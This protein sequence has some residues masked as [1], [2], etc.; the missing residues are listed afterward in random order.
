MELNRQ[1]YRRLTTDQVATA[2]CTDPVQ[3]RFLTSERIVIHVDNK[4]PISYCRGRSGSYRSISSLAFSYELMTD[5]EITT[6]LFETLLEWLGPDREKAAEKYETIRTR[7]IKIFVKK[8]CSDPDT[9]FDTTVN[10]VT[11]K[12]PEMVAGYVGDPL[13]YFISV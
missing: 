10:R 6:E 9:L 4:A 1:E 8:G 2:P 5:P 13:W 12:L 11:L 3:V 7:L